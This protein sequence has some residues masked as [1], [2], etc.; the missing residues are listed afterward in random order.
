MADKKF[1]WLVKRS[2]ETS[3]GD[4]DSTLSPC[5]N[6]YSKAHDRFVYTIGQMI[7]EWED[8]EQPYRIERG[9]NYIDLCAD[10]D[11]SDWERVE[12]IEKELIE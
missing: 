4:R 12:L 10:M 5:Y 8:F 1:V 6:T 9:E 11:G 2:W 7:T 3:E